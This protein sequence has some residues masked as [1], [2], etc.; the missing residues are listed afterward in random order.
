MQKVTLTPKTEALKKVMKNWS[1]E[2]KC[3][4]SHYYENA[5]RHIERWTKKHWHSRAETHLLCYHDAA[6]WV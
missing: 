4:S 5:R 6:T 1:H 3:A 2:L